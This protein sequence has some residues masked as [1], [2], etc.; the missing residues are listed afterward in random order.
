MLLEAASTGSASMSSSAV[1]LHDGKGSVP[2]P[3]IALHA[4]SASRECSLAL[5]F[6]AGK[7]VD[8]NVL[9]PYCMK[10]L[11]SSL[12]TYCVSP[13]QGGLNLCAE[14]GRDEPAAA[15]R[16]AA[17]SSRSWSWASSTQASAAWTRT[18]C[19][20]V[21]PVLLPGSRSGTGTS[22][23]LTLLLLA[24]MNSCGQKSLRGVNAHILQ[25]RT[26]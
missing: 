4:K 22:K 14:N 7:S 12:C 18:S 25:A 15:R 6:R 9:L 19:R 5:M 2:A 20:R 26:S 24:C 17:P 11:S 1:S 13:G 21:F 3:V 16:A 10:G 23:Q 8:R